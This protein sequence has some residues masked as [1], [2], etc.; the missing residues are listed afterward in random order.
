MRKIYRNK[1]IS[2]SVG[3]NEPVNFEVRFVSDGNS[4][5]TSINIPGDYDPEIHDS[6]LTNIGIGSNLRQADKTIVVSDII[7]PAPEEDDIIIEYYINNN[8]VHR[9]EN[10]KSESD[11]PL[12]ILWIKFN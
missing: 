10:P 7:N 4:G 2:V 8:L 12:I 9:H 11:Q 1:N 3:V 5:V 6:G